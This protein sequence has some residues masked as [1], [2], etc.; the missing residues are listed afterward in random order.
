MGRAHIRVHNVVYCMFHGEI[1]GE[2][3][4]PYGYGDVD[5]ECEDGDHRKVYAAP[6][7]GDTVDAGEMW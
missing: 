5:D 7:K 3:T 2:T 4:D 6:R 1:H